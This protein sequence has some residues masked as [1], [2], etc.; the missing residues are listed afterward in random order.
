MNELEFVNGEIFANVWYKDRIARIDPKTGR[1]NSWLELK[2]LRPRGTDR[3][4]AL[5]GIAWDVTNKRLFVT[6]KTWPA[7]YEIAF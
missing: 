1:V 4:D 5:N 2:P 7:L 3:E 6:G